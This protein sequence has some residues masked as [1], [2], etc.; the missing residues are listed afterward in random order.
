MRRT[1]SFEALRPAACKRDP[2]ILLQDS[3]LTL[4]S[5]PNLTHR[6]KAEAATRPADES[7]SNSQTHNPMHVNKK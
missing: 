7:A 6:F 2:G 1:S 3:S 4:L 5:P